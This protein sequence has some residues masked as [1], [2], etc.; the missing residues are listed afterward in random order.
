VTYTTTTTLGRIE[1][2]TKWIKKDTGELTASSTQIYFSYSVP[3]AHGDKVTVDGLDHDVLLIDEKQLFS[4]NHHK[5][6]YL[7]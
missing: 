1:R 6:V 3:L 7:S 5:K 4:T 2:S